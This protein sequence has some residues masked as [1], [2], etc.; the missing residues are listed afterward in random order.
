MR[1]QTLEMQTNFQCRFLLSLIP[2]AFWLREISVTKNDVFVVDDAKIP[3]EKKKNK[4]YFSN[5]LVE[6]RYMP[7]GVQNR[8]K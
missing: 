3:T 1:G 8:N 5:N 4:S 7:F 2:E 6:V